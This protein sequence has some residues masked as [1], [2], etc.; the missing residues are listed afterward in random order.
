VWWFVRFI[1]LND[2]GLIQNENRLVNEYRSQNERRRI[3]CP[4]KKKNAI[5]TNSGNN[6]ASYKTRWT[7]SGKSWTTNAET[8]DQLDQ[9]DQSPH[10]HLIAQILTRADAQI[11]RSDIEPERR[12]VKPEKS[13]TR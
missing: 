12:D 11:R 7:P 2:S 1:Y 4:K 9:N 10:S 13:G 3:Q 8:Q 6:S 5:S